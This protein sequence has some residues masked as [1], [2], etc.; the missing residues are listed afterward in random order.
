MGLT[1]KEIIKKKKEK[2]AN[3]I[4][5]T[6]TSIFLIVSGSMNIAFMSKY[7]IPEK[8]S[9]FIGFSGLIILYIGC[10]LLY[11]TTEVKNG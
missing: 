4:M 6:L 5:N 7:T 1:K 2:I 9:F 11:K 10:V 8:Y 3:N